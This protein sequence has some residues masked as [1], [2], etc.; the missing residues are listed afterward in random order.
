M[1]LVAQVEHKTLETAR[2]GQLIEEMVETALET[3]LDY[4]EEMAGQV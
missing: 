1:P 3:V 4:L 2:L